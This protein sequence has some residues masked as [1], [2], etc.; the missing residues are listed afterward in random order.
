M[1]GGRAWVV[2]GVRN[3]GMCVVQTLLCCANK[4]LLINRGALRQPHTLLPT[5]VV[6]AP[7]QVSPLLG[8]AAGAVEPQVAVAPPLEVRLDLVQHA[9]HGAEQQHLAAGGH[10]AEEG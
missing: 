10:A 7:D 2:D 8:A 5:G 4:L 9:R 6:E 3:V 1:E